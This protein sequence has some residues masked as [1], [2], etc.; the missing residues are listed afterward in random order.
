VLRVGAQAGPDRVL[1]N[2]FDRCTEVLVALDHPRGEA[3]AEEVARAVVA[4]VEGL[5]IDAVQ[6][7]DAVGQT[8]ELGFHDEV[9][10]VRHQ[11]ERVDAPVVTAND[12]GQKGEEVPALV[13]VEIDRRARHA[14][15]RDV[16]DAFRRKLAPRFPHGRRR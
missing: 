16:V 8:P 4:A 6:A 2:V 7:L 5:C 3:V 9:V 13:V 10:V 12:V 1:E 15:R 11:A 14:S